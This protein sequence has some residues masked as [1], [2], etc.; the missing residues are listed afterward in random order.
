MKQIIYIIICVAA[1]SACTKEIDFE[2]RDEAPLVVI[3]G[4]VT[5]EGRTVI[6]S[7]TRSVTDSVHSHCLPGA[8]IVISGGGADT[9]LTYDAAADCYYSPIPG[10]AG[11][12]YQ[13]SVDFEGQHYEAEA[14]MPDAA[15]ILTSEFSWITMMGQRM[16]CYEMWGVDPEPDVR[17]Y[18]WI[19]M[20]RIS[21]HPHLEDTRQTAP[22]GWDLMDDRGCPPGQIFLDWML[23]S[24]E[25]MD[26]DEEKDWK[27]IIYDGDSLWLTLM[28]VD[29]KV[30][31]YLNQL[32]MGQYNGAN[33]RTNI[34]GGCMGYF[35]AGSITRSD[36][37]VFR[38][39]NIREWDMT[40]GSK[41]NKNAKK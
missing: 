39:A 25:K 15:P 31:D 16:L 10:V 20:N 22:Y 30:Y 34:S 18:Y 11:Q 13:L 28:T 5:N 4:K 17:N 9:Q 33:P 3:E 8:N 23:V 6:V 24:E 29:P 41:I 21:H 19:R 37:V 40:L 7:R 12:T 1:F 38:R 32:R 2:F 26:K 14:S 35:A 27:R 36:T